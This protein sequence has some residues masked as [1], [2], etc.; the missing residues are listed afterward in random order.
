MRGS[1]GWPAAQG[2]RGMFGAPKHRRNWHSQS[3][4]AGERRSDCGGRIEAA[5]GTAR[6]FWMT[7]EVANDQPAPTTGPRIQLSAPTVVEYS[8][9]ETLAAAVPYIFAATMPER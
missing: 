8:A 6:S 4:G 7:C 3:D 5:L 9:E 2:K 1:W